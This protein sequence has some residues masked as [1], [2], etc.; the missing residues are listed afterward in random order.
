MQLI[1]IMT[2]KNG[3]LNGET[4]SRIAVGTHISMVS[5]DDRKES[6]RPHI[7][8][9]KYGLVP[10]NGQLPISSSTASSSNIE[11]RS[12]ELQ[13]RSDFSI[14]DS[15][16]TVNLSVS[17]QPS[18]NKRNG[19]SQANILYDHYDNYLVPFRNGNHQ[20][21]CSPVSVIR[22]SYY[23]VNFQDDA[24]ISNEPINLTATESKKRKEIFR[25][26]TNLP[27]KKRKKQL[28]F[29]IQEASESSQRDGMTKIVTQHRKC[30]KM[31]N[32]IDNSGSS[33]Y[34]S[35]RF[36]DSRTAVIHPIQYTSNV[37]SMSQVRNIKVETVANVKVETP[38]KS[39]IFI[40][41]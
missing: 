15:I 41:Y 25:T 28:A 11:V 8:N 36:D 34:I 9:T 30:V 24:N 32:T 12:R 40:L 31:K 35:S 6:V 38:S 18:Q 19:F 29:E 22:K 5:M 23:D 7:M 1:L 3:S 14:E 37:P 20:V 27:P 39:G 26:E 4:E 16:T 33:G 10:Y 21:P 17:T 2:E 13:S